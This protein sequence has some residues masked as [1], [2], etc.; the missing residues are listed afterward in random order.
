[1]FHATGTIAAIIDP[2]A[3]SHIIQLFIDFVTGS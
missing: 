2:S 1:M 3:F